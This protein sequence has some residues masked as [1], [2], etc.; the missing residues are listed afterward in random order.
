VAGEKRGIDLGKA[1]HFRKKA[2]P[3]IRKGTKNQSCRRAGP[4]R[5]VKE[6]K[7]KEEKRTR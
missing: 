3:P 7:E 2:D 6:G 5:G 4:K 1:R